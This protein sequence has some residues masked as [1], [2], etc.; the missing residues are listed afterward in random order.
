MKLWLKDIKRAIKNVS[1]ISLSDS[2]AD[3]R[4]YTFDVDKDKKEFKYALKLCEK[5][6]KLNSSCA[7]FCL[8]S[9]Y[10]T[11]DINEAIDYYKKSAE[12]NYFPSLIRLG[13]LYNSIDK[14]IANHYFDRAKDCGDNLQLYNLARMY[15]AKYSPIYDMNK[16]LETYGI[17]ASNGHERSIIRLVLYYNEKIF[18]PNKEEVKFKET[19][20]I[21][22]LDLEISKSDLD[23]EKEFIECFNN[24]SKEDVDA[25][26][27][28][29]TVGCDFACKDLMFYAYVYYTKG[30][31]YNITQTEAFNYLKQ[32]AELN[33]RE[34][35]ESLA[36]EYFWGRITQKN[37]AEAYKWYLKCLVDESR[38]LEKLG[39]IFSLNEG[40][41]VD[42]NQ[43]FTYYW[44]AAEKDNANAQFKLGVFYE[45]G[46]GCNVDMERAKEW[47]LKAANNGHQ[48][49]KD[50]LYMDGHDIIV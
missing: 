39:D 44:R 8:A 45:E 24:A 50:R 27:N 22:K 32:S 2:E 38:I 16:A 20:N 6:A 11:I 12:Y 17:A 21:Y 18:N 35:W 1:K 19:E 29:T 43:A 7:L 13:E 10:E 34:A 30:I 42:Y 3:C 46:K 25:L 23:K 36:N 14:E 37:H 47:Y 15:E 4:Y 41:E 5:V 49:A 48:E 33:C 31:G 28:W 40:V 9:M 26:F